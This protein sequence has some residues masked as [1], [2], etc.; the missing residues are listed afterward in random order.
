M[1]VSYQIHKLFKNDEKHTDARII[2][3]VKVLFIDNDTEISALLYAISQS[4][5]SLMA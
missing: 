4:S 5:R 3:H 1:K 2:I